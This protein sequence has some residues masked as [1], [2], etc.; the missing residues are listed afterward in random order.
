MKTKNRILSLAAVLCIMALLLPYAAAPVRA[1]DETAGGVYTVTFNPNGGTVS[2]ESA[3]TGPDGKL[4]SLPTPERENYVF[5]HWA[6][7]DGSVVFEYS[8]FTADTTVYATWTGKPGNG[9]AGSGSSAPREPIAPETLTA[10]GSGSTSPVKVTQDGTVTVMGNIN[11]SDLAQLTS[12]GGPVVLDTSELRWDVREIKLPV[13]NLRSIAEAAGAGGTDALTVWLA[14]GAVTLDAE[15]LSTAVEKASGRNLSLFLDEVGI[16]KLMPEQQAAVRDMEVLAVYD[17]HLSNDGNMRISRFGDGS[18]TI[19]VKVHEGAENAAVW[20]VDGNGTLEEQ[21]AALADGVLSW[22]V[23]HF[24]FYVLTAGKSGAD[25]AEETAG[26]AADETAD[27]PAEEADG[28]TNDETAD[29]PAEE[30]DGETNDETAGL[31]AEETDGEAA[32]ETAEAPEETAGAADGAVC[33]KDESCPIAAFTDAE[34]SAW[35]HDGVHYALE[36]GIMGGIGSGK[37]NP[38]GTASRAMV[39]TM[40]WRLAGSPEA[41][42]PAEFN[43]VS[44]GDWYAG[45]VSWA[46][47]ENIITGYDDPSEDGKLFDP[48]SA[49]N[50]D[51]LATMLYRYA[52][53]QGQGFE[54][55][56]AFPLEYPDA[57]EVSEWAYEPMCWMTMHGIIGGINGTLSPAENAT[58]AQIATMFLRYRSETAQ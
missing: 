34:P 43:D 47:A 25:A 14:D 33:A 42:Q 37:F 28:E 48:N 4:G 52:Q 44:A 15:A 17:V 7:A 1:A 54:E 57:A 13:G 10:S 50:R 6:F 18:V 32:D 31:P 56:G 16:G 55:A 12:S 36:N 51:Q 3:K 24:S 21:S 38:D 23:N 45:A 2:P 9:G 39:A 46:N 29:V 22:Q 19:S 35:Y 30:T 53:S 20:Y 58:R 5:K 8:V 26:E 27:V 40:L 49:V 11:A 41:A